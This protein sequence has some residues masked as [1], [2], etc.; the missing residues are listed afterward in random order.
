MIKATTPEL[1]RARTLEDWPTL[2]AEVPPLVGFALRG[3][4]YQSQDYQDLKQEGLLAGLNAVRTW[5]PDMDAFS[6]HVVMKVRY[7]LLDYLRRN[8]SV[9]KRAAA[10]DFPLDADD[11]D[12]EDEAGGPLERLTYAEDAPAGFG[13]P[14]VE[15]QRE[16]AQEAAEGLLAQAD[17]ADQDVLRSLY[18]IGRPKETV[19]DFATR[20]GVPV[21]GPVIRRVRNAERYLEQRQKTPVKRSTRR[22]KA[23]SGRGPLRFDVRHDCLHI[24]ADRYPGF[25]NGL[26]GVITMGGAW[27]ES[28]GRVFAD[29]AWKP[30]AE[31]IKRGSKP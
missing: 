8:Q 3:I 13:D 5:R 24:P 30:T 10:P 14:G 7:A 20:T 21:G 1:T 25:W 11:G 4:K 9:V 23:G 28:T 16:T 31:D 27:R 19:R 22:V 29:W 2:N 17:P 18:G 6:T 26:A 15:L 12:P